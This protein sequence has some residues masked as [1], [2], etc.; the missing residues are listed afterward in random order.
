MALAQSLKNH[1]ARVT[2]EV[3]FSGWDDRHQ[4]SARVEERGRGGCCTPV[5]GY[6]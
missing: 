6:Q 2:L 3:V 4:G 1:L 5:V